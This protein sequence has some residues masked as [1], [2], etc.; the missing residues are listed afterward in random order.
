[1]VF[2]GVFGRRSHRLYDESSQL[3]PGLRPLTELLEQEYES[4]CYL[5]GFAMPKWVP[6]N[7]DFCPSSD[8]LALC[9]ETGFRGL[10]GEETNGPGPSEST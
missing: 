10:A 2:G 8:R 6:K 5:K 7:N 4:P 1:V 9:V 3:A